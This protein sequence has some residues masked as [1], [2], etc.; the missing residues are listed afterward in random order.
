MNHLKSVVS[1]IAVSIALLVG[2]IAAQSLVRPQIG[3]LI[4]SVPCVTMTQCQ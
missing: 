1:V 4:D 2:N 3:G